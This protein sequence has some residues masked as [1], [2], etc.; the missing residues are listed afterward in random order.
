MSAVLRP[1]ADFSPLAIGDLERI[2]PIEQEIYPFPW[3]L[4]NF[5]D[6]LRAGYNGWVYRENDEIVGYSVCMNVLDEVHLLNLSIAAH[7]QGR[8]HGARLLR[9]L[10]DLHGHSG[11]RQMLLEVRPSNDAALRLYRQF[12]FRRIGV[13]RGYYPAVGGRE[14]AWVMVRSLEAC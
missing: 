4:G 13:R 10:L 1:L 14:D 6:A 11:G 3:T 9:F 2:V 12:G 5:I 8:G 7:W